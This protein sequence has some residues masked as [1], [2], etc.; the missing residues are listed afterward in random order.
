MYLG[1]IYT[2]SV[3]MAGLPGLVMPCGFDAEGLP[4]GAQ[5]I[6]QAFG[7]QALLNCAHAYQQHTSWHRQRPLCGQGKEA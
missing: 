6:G 1:D 2:L 3:N 5:L 4:V 7:E